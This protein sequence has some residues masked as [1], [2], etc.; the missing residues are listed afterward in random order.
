MLF[1]LPQPVF[2]K[3][4]ITVEFICALICLPGKILSDQST[5]D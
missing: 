2:V 4:Y 1:G 3:R 5:F